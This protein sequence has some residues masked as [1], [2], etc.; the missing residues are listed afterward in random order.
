MPSLKHLM[1]EYLE[2][3]DKTIEQF[4]DLLIEDWVLVLSKELSDD[5]AEEILDQLI[6]TRANTI[7]KGTN[8]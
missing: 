5:K 4:I 8:L 2:I 6:G 3:D 1:K 7:A